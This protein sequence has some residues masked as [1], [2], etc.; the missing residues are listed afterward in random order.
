MKW[1]NLQSILG[2]NLEVLLAT[3][4]ILQLMLHTDGKVDERLQGSLARSHATRW[5]RT[6]L[7][8][9]GPGTRGKRQ[10]RQRPRDASPT[11]ARS[12][13]R[14][15]SASAFSRSPLAAPA[16]SRGSPPARAVRMPQGSTDAG[17]LPASL[18]GDDSSERQSF[19][20]P[21]IAV[22]SKL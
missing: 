14:H 22:S 2:Q 15:P 8:V 16:P 18:P 3:K 21:I 6:M 19:G 17:P 1:S 12:T 5:P 9:K 7:I 20:F 13:L 10:A 11:T 4:W